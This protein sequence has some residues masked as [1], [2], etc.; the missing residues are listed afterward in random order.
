MTSWIIYDEVGVARNEW[1]ITTFIQ[2]AKRYGVDLSLK[3]VSGV[4]DLFGEHLPNFAIVRTIA[5]QINLFLEEQDIPTFN[6]HQT[7]KI[8]NDKWQTYLL[9]KQL[10][11]PVMKTELLIDGAPSLNFPFVLKSLS[12][13]GGKEVFLIRDRQVLNETLSSIEKNNF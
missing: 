10:N 9:C 2:T 8:A 13:H 1:F 12:G 7:S 5:P 11:I 6:N 3:V 4:E